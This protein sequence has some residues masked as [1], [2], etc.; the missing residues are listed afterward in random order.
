MSTA[1]SEP[2]RGDLE[3]VRAAVGSQR[4]RLA[5]GDQV[6]DRQ[7]Q[8]RLDHLGQPGG[9]VVET[10]GVDRHRVAGAV[11]LHPRAVE[12]RL[13]NGRAAQ[14]VERVGDVGRG[15][16][17]HRPDRPADLQ[18]ELL[19]RGLHRR[20]VRRGR[21]GGQVAAEH[22]RAPHHRG[23]HVGRLGDRVGHH[24][25]QRALPQFTAEQPTQERLLVVGGRR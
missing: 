9:D 8:R 20:S 18:G 3:P 7:R 19:Q 22:R 16:G 4:D 5:V 21:D 24:A 15:L 1:A 2:R 12:L 25:E 13:E 6:G 10:S 23:G 17:E 11:D 14:A